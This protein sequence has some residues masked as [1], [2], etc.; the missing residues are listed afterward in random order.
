MPIGP[1]IT[2]KD[3]ENINSVLK[4]FR[5]ECNKSG[6]KNELKKR[7]Y[8]LAPSELKNIEQSKVKRLRLK[9]KRRAERKQELVKTRK[10]RG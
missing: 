7:R 1:L 4:R 5:R 6:T 10:R 9:D 2:K 8:F 3:N